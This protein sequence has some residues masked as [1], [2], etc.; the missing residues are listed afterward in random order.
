MKSH[1]YSSVVDHAV[2]NQITQ[3]SIFDGGKGVSLVQG[4]QC[5]IFDDGKGVSLVQGC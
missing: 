3:Y 4:C 2:E 1:Q 5:S